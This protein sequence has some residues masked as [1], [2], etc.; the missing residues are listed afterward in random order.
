MIVYAVKEQYTFESVTES[1]VTIYATKEK[2]L[3]KFREVVEEEKNNSWIAELNDVIEETCDLERGDYFAY[4]DGRACEYST[5][6]TISTL[7][8]IE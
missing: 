7:P 8:V 6:I 1:R 3:A 5:E 2:A 4:V